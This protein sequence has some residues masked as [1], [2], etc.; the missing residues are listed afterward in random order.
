MICLYINNLSH[1]N[2]VVFY[3]VFVKCFYELQEN[4]QKIVHKQKFT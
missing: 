3:V 2:Y 1:V 4:K